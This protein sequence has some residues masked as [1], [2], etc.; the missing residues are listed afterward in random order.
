MIPSLCPSRHIPYHRVGPCCAASLVAHP[1][2]FS[3]LSIL[4]ILPIPFRSFYYA[5]EC[6][7]REFAPSL[8]RK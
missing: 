2:F 4:P 1:S 6:F 7:L 8:V 3:F 5:A